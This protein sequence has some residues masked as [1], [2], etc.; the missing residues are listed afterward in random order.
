MSVS[1]R[2]KSFISLALMPGEMRFRMFLRS[3]ANGRTV[4]SETLQI[5]IGTL[6]LFRESMDPAILAAAY[7]KTQDPVLLRLLSQEDVPAAQWIVTDKFKAG[8]YTPGFESDAGML[9]LNDPTMIALLKKSAENPDMNV[10]LGANWAL[11]RA[12]SNQAY[13]DFVISVA[14]EGAGLGPKT[15]SLSPW[16]GLDAL[17][18]LEV[19]DSPVAA[20]AL[21]DIA[22]AGKKAPNSEMFAGAF[23]SL[24]FV[25][26][27]YDYV[28]QTLLSFMHGELD[29]HNIDG[30]MMFEI[31]AAR[32]TPELA[33]AA[34]ARS[35]DAYERNFIRMRGYAV[36]N[37]AIRY[38]TTA[39]PKDVLA[40][41]PRRP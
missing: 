31:A 19:I 6:H 9:A 23:A 25:Q 16:T 4:S 40:R 30:N 5:A 24:F 27:D 39:I 21:R 33:A 38:M 36:E 34:Q 12:T 28:D 41:L 37:I 7:D 26:R 1:W 10:R 13:L 15:G 14:N 32:N 2:Q 35:Q 17:Q 8:G 20:R 29:G 18:Y 22:D 11:Y 3:A